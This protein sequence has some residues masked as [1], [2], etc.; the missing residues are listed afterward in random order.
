MVKEKNKSLILCILLISF[1]L[2]AIPNAQAVAGESDSYL[3]FDG[4]AKYA[5]AADS[6]A[7]NTFNAISIEFWFKSSLATCS[8]NIV[9]KG[10]DYVVYCNSGRIAYAF[11]SASV[12]ATGTDVRYQSTTRVAYLNVPQNEWHHFAITRAANTNSVTTYWDGQK[13]SDNQAADGASTYA[14]KATA[15]PLNIGARRNTTTYFSGGIDEVRISNVVRTQAEIQSDMNTWGIGS[16]TG[17]VA[18]YDFN[19]IS[20]STLTDRVNG[21]NMSLVGAPTSSTI[22][23]KTT[24]G[25]DTVISFP[26]SYLTSQGG[27]KVPDGITK[28]ESLVIAGGGAGGSRA[29]GGGGAGGYV[30]TDR[31]TLTYTPNQVQVITVGVG[32]IGQSDTL[33]GNGTNSM[34]GT[35]R[36]AIGGGGGGSASGVGNSL[37]NGQDGGSGGGAAVQHTTGLVYGNSIQYSTTGYGVGYY[38]ALALGAN[39]YPGGGGGGA[40]GYASPAAA[41]SATDWSAGGAGLSNSI[42]GSAVC[43]ATGGGGGLGQLN[44]SGAY[45]LASAGGNCGGSANPNNGRGMYGKAQAQWGLGN[46]G[47]GGGGTGFDDYTSGD[48]PGGHGGS[49]IIILRYTST[50][51]SSF[52]G[53]VSGIYRTASSMSVTTNIGAKVTFYANGKRI[54]GCIAIKTVNLVATCNWKPSSRGQL[55]ITATSTPLF[56]GGVAVTSTSLMSVGRRTESR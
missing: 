7:L 48:I 11:Q 45:S 31:A 20:G 24:V 53:Q 33:G 46:T 12:G 17:V 10:V 5:T 52:T 49:G 39:F 36:T 35:V 23:S 43:Y 16:E 30:A 56:A 22:E 42:T 54:A 51:T 34:L 18:Y 50:L 2:I 4:T 40:G 47:A 9:S 27:W 32:G 19:D 21:N 3:N 8:G 28:I 13:V 41:S 29:G 6:A 15:D 26:R 14:L 38:G 55:N 44:L 1:T 25:N 37:R